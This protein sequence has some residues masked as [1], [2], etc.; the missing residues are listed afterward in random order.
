MWVFCV[1]FSVRLGGNSILI[2]SNKAVLFENAASKLYYLQFITTGI[3][4]LFNEHFQ[5]VVLIEAIDLL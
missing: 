5:L 2:A 1:K 4:T 3:S